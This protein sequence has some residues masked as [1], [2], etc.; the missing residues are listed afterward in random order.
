MKKLL[1]IGCCVA[2]LTI[3]GCKLVPPGSEAGGAAGSAGDQLTQEQLKLLEDIKTIQQQTGQTVQAL[4]QQARE[5]EQ[6]ALAEQGLPGIVEDIAAAQNVLGDA[7][8]A[9]QLKRSEA[10]DASLTRLEGIFITMLSELP[11]HRIA[12]YSERA[13]AYLHLPQPRLKEASAELTAAYDV[14][15][16]SADSA[17]VQ[18]LIQQAKGHLASGNIHGAGEVLHS[19]ITRAGNDDTVKLLNE[20]LEGVAGARNALNRRSW[21]VMQA[22]LLEVR[23][24]L[25]DLSNRVHFTESMSAVQPQATAAET[26]GSG[27]TSPEGAAAPQ[28]EAAAPQAGAPAEPAAT[29]PREPADTGVAQPPA[30]APSPE[31]PT[32]AA[33]AG[34]PAPQ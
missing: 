28:S 26:T 9:A 29:Q 32:T 8:E 17:G 25:D 3:I 5:Q 14:C 27:E 24:M 23:R 31:A 19:T 4:M 2:A 10:A 33:G 16:R 30:A 21:P 18:A 12:G 22:E 13:L 7:S 1:L 20:M 6:R 34:E 15:V 11:A